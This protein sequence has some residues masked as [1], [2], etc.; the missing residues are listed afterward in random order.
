VSKSIDLD[1][2]VWYA[3]LPVVGYIF[4]V[5]SGVALALHLDM[6]STALALSMVVLLVTGIHNAWDITVWTITR[7]RDG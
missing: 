2:K 6:G 3:V 7:L 4:E 1:D 5:V